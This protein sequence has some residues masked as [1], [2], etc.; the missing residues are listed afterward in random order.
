MQDCWTFSLYP[1]AA[2]GGGASPTSC[3]PPSAIRD[4]ASS[5]N[6]ISTGTGA[7]RSVM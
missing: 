1:Q 6:W 3:R 2:E 7:L 5:V 4:S